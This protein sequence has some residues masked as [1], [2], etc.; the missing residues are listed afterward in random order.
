MEENTN[1]STSQSYDKKTSGSQP[2]ESKKAKKRRDKRLQKLRDA[3][4]KMRLHA[5]YEEPVRPVLSK[6]PIIT[7]GVGAKVYV[8]ALVNLILALVALALIIFVLPKVLIWFL[9]LVISLIISAIANP[10]VRFLKNKVKI[11]RKVSSAIVIV[12]VVLLVAG[13]LFG[14]GY[15][16]VDECRKLYENRETMM[17]TV[18]KAWNAAGEKLS[19]VYNGLPPQL[20]KS[21]SEFSQ[22]LPNKLQDLFSGF[23]LEK[24]GNAFGVFGGFIDILLA[25]IACILGAYFFTAQHDEINA[26]LKRITPQSTQ[27]Y[28]KLVVDNFKKAIGG[29]FKAQFIILLIVF[30]IQCVVFLIMGVPYAALVAFLV[31]FLDFLPVFG[32]GAVYWPWI[33]IDLIIGGEAAIAQAIWLAV[34]YIVLQVVRQLLQPKLVSD[35]VEMNPLITLI[36]MY[37]GYRLGSIGGLIIS[38]PIGMIVISLYKIGAFDR[39]IRSIRTLCELV[40]NFRKN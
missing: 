39:V 17:A 40:N 13:I 33:A 31:A 35:A 2:Y 38:I 34:L 21:V 19:S 37:I 28:Y 6:E 27:D 36:C 30:A 8:K 5:E 11:A 29:Y 25:I 16:A 1:T 15:V 32:M 23:D 20:Q 26:A 9:P 4:E 14:I 22:D 3:R 10:L 7:E 18:E 12:L 24:I